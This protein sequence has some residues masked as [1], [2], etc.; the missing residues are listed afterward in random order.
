MGRLANIGS[1]SI[2]VNYAQGASQRNVQPVANFIAPGVDVAA[3]TGRY[4]IYNEAVRFKLPKVHRGLGGAAT[5]LSWDA[6]DGTYNCTP[7]ALDL[8]I[9]LL[10]AIESEGMENVVQEG[11]DRVAAT[12]GLSHE[13][14]V[15]DLALASATNTNK[16]WSSGTPDIIDEIDNEI[17]T[18]IKAAKYGSIMGVGVVFGPTAWRLA[19]N[20]AS[21]KGRYIV[22]AGG[23]AKNIGQVAPGISDFGKL[24]IGEPE[25]ML[26]TMVR[27]TAKEGLAESINFVMDSTVLIFARRADPDRADPSFMKTFRLNGQWMKPGSYMSPDGRSEVVKFDWSSDVKVTNS[28]AGR[29]LTIS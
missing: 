29:K 13:T 27:D 10:E 3:M 12:A 26:S 16:T 20:N 2:L 24:L 22:G 7:K 21:V 15:V 23:S 6:T 17:L 9:D 28:S 4:K 8:P 25:V 14:E 11:A 5:M 1:N 18:V 19:K